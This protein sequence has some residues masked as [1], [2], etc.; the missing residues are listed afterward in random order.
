MQDRHDLPIVIKTLP[1][2]EKVLARE[3]RQIGGREIMEIR[4]GIICKGDLG[5]VY[6]CNLWLRTAV[7]VLIQL[8]RFQVRDENH[9]YKMIK[10]I[11][12][13]DYFAVNQTIAVD[14]TVFSD[15]FRNSLF[16]AQKTKDAVVDRF[17]DRE[18][19]RPSVDIKN[20]DIRLNV[21]IQKQYCTVSLDSSGASLYKRGYRTEVD[22]APLNEVLAA[23]ILALIDWQGKGPLIDPMCGSGTFLTEA[24]LYASNVPVNVFRKDYSFQNWKAYQPELFNTIFEAAPLPEIRGYDIDPKVLAKSRRNIKNALMDEVIKVQKRN[25]LK[26]PE[27]AE[28]KPGTTVV[29]NPPYDL[30]IEADIPT[31]YK[32]IGDTLKQHFSNCTAW[33]FTASIDGLKHLGLKPSQKIALKN[34]NLDSWLVRYDLYEGTKKNKA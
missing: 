10:K 5:F 1:G 23:G 25:F 27:D 12:W 31:L 17:R 32:G 4:R 33:V 28:I 34:G 11:A 13:E 2:L 3:V 18:G 29:F 26:W 7:R 14:A 8:D 16:I 15:R 19:K 9:L 21:H 24:A 20:P 22:K 30:K 6:K